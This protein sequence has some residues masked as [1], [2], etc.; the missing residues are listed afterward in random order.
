MHIHDVPGI[1]DDGPMHPKSPRVSAPDGVV[2]LLYKMGRE[3]WLKR[4]L[5]VDAIQDFHLEMSDAPYQTLYIRRHGRDVEVRNELQSRVGD[6]EH[7]A[8]WFS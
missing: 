7:G 5:D 3:D 8:V 2:T 6:D 1:S 4:F